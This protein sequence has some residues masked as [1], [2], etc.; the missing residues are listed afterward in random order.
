MAR[1]GGTGANIKFTSSM[2]EACTLTGRLF[3]MPD[4]SF[5]PQHSKT[6]MSLHYCKPKRKKMRSPHMNGWA[7]L[8]IKV[9]GCKYQKYD[10]RLKEQFISGVN[11]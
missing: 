3:A 5:R 8:L 11:N 4:E 1:K 2:K 6:M 9:A 10:S 7:R